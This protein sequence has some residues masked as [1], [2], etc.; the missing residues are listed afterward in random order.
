MPP[1]DFLRTSRKTHCSSEAVLSISDKRATIEY[2]VVQHEIKK[3]KENKNLFFSCK[4]CDCSFSS[5]NQHI[6]P[7]GGL[8]HKKKQKKFKNKRKPILASSVIWNLQDLAISILTWKGDVI[9]LHFGKFKVSFFYIIGFL[10]IGKKLLLQI[11]TKASS[12]KLRYESLWKYSVFTKTFKP[13]NSAQQ[14]I[15][16]VLFLPVNKGPQPDR[17]LCI[18]I[19]IYDLSSSFLHSEEAV[20][21]ANT[22]YQILRDSSV[23]YGMHDTQKPRKA[24]MNSALLTH[25]LLKKG[26]KLLQKSE[27]KI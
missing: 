2:V 24:I 10:L 26:M 1:R 17:A 8:K 21:G 15:Y 12:L 27:L 14:D 25:F 4:V 23:L 7:F 16:S 13:D 20:E 6:Q 9:A 5:H 19:V 22:V 3:I 11:K 18:S